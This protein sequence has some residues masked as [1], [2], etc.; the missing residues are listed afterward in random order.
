M[1]WVRYD[2]SQGMLVACRLNLFKGY[3]QKKKIHVK[4]P[5]LGYFVRGLPHLLSL[6]NLVLAEF[7]LYE[8]M[9]RFDIL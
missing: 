9:F 5:E 3:V 7:C 4:G 1:L 6:R 8:F 2:A